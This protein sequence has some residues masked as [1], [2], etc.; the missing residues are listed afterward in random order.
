MRTKDIVAV[1]EAECRLRCVHPFD[2]PEDLWDVAAEEPGLWHDA[3]FEAPR[4]DPT[5][6]IVFLYCSRRVLRTVRAVLS[7]WDRRFFVE[8]LEYW[9]CHGVEWLQERGAVTMAA[10][11]SMLEA[12]RSVDPV[13]W[14]WHRAVLVALT[15]A[16]PRARRDQHRASVGETITWAGHTGVV[17][18]VGPD[19][20]EVAVG[21]A[22]LRVPYGQIVR[23]DGWTATL[24]P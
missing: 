1:V 6:E 21:R 13:G 5:G 3:G 2:V 22:R 9:I 14:A 8:L 17:V 16:G 18:H 15:E 10:E 4:W 24:M 11:A 7:G 12:L 23:L 20:I 19:G